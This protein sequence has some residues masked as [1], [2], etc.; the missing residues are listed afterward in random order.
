MPPGFCDVRLEPSVQRHFQVYV[1]IHQTFSSS[2]SYSTW[3]PPAACCCS[4]SCIAVE[5]GATVDD[6]EIRVSSWTAETASP[7]GVDEGEK[8]PPRVLD[9]FLTPGG[10]RAAKRCDNEDSSETTSERSSSKI[11]V[12]SPPY[13]WGT[14]A[15]RRRLRNSPRSQR[16]WSAL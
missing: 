8:F 10:L 7:R 9:F 13:C 2:A 16:A 1:Q 12:P 3:Q 15:R 11:D 6:H 5:G 14:P 4:S